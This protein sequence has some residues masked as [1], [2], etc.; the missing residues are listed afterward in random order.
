DPL[1]PAPRLAQVLKQSGCH[2]V[3]TTSDLRPTLLQV[4]DTQN[5]GLPVE[6]AEVLLLETLLAQ[7]PSHTNLPAR[8]QFGQLA[9]VIYTSGS[10][11]APKGVMVEHGGMLNHIFA[12]ISDV[13]LTHADIVAQNGP[14]S[15][16]ISVWQCFAALLLGGSVQVFSNE[17]ISDP[18]RLLEQIEEKAITILQLVPSMLRA[19]LD[20]LTGVECPELRILRWLIPTGDALPTDLC[21]Q[22]LNLYPTIPVLNTYGS[23]E[24]SDDQCHYAITAPLA[25]ENELP[26]MPIGFPIANMRAYVLDEMLEL[27]PIGV[28]GELYI[29]GLG[30]GRGYLNDP[31]RT[32]Q[33]FLPDLFG[34]Q[35]GGRLY[36]TRDRARYLTDGNIEFLGRIDHLVKVR[37][38]RI[39]L[40]EIEA[41]LSQHPQVRA[42]IVLA[43]KRERTG[44][45]WLMAYVVPSQFPAPSTEELRS[46]LEGKLPS[47][48]L[49]S[50]FIILEAL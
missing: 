24:C 42:S 28:V 38:Y 46:Y 16:D 6:H 37:G 13:Q 20:Q 32:A 18:A 12:K 10:T 8:C 45:T 34:Q 39:E 41:V 7:T 1:H 5:E 40:G 11:G 23:T 33:V 50:R 9:Y 36:R 22:W 3:L 14:Q 21:R 27:V 15:F 30:V 19:L 47:Y 17:M 2:L 44:S 31:E 35:A 43:H 25:G 29:G 49:P 48:M 26:I 4:L